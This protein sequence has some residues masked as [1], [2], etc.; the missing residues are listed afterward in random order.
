[1]NVPSDPRSRLVQE[2]KGDPWQLVDRVI[3]AEA[4][5]EHAEEALRDALAVRLDTTPGLSNNQVYNGA[6][7]AMRAILE[8]A[9]AGTAAPAEPAEDTSTWTW[10][11]GCP[12][13]GPH[14]DACAFR[15]GAD[16]AEEAETDECRCRIE[17]GG[18]SYRGA[19]P[20]HRA[21]AER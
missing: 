14:N 5:A 7:L 3:T 19:C 21:E 18:L 9:L 2:V 10:D 13:N 17:I 1:M 15:A 16:P 20:I 4:R 6:R 11:C 8:E 12:F